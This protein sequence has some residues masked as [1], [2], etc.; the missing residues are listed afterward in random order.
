MNSGLNFNAFKRVIILTGI[1]SILVIIPFL[2]GC[3]KL[4]ESE[5]PSDFVSG[6]GAF[7]SDA[8]ATAVLNAIYATLNNAD[9]FFQGT[10]S[11]S[12]Y[13]GLSSDELT[14]YGG[15]T[16]NNYLAHYRNSLNQIV[17]QGLSGTQ[18]WAPL[19][20]LIF[21]CNAAIE[22]LEASEALT[23]GVKAQLIGESRF[24]R[25]FFYF[26]LVN[27]FGD[28]PLIISTDPEASAIASRSTKSMVYKQLVT[29]LQVAA[30]SLSENYL[31]GSLLKTS[32]ERV[33]PV[34][35]TA[36]ALLSRVYL[37][38]ENWIMAEQ[39]ASL[40]I[41]NSQYSL[42]PLTEVFLKTSK[43]AIWQLQPTAINFNT[44][45]AQTTVIPQAG[46]NTTTN[47]VFLSDT[48]LNSFETGDL[49]Y[50]LGNWV[51]TTIYKVT[52]TLY[53]TVAY[54]NKYKYNLSDPS[55]TTTTG[56][57]NMKEYFVVLR[58]AE[59]YL[60]RAEAR[61]QQGNFNGGKD[62]LNII[63]KRAFGGSKPTVA[64]D[65]TTLLAAI[66]QERKA[67]LF[68]EFGHR[69]LDLKRTGKIEEVMNGITPLKA[70]GLPWMS[71]QQ[72][73]PIPLSDINKDPYLTQNDG[74]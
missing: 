44:T 46:P 70:G 30:S 49:R 6:A 9:G 40:L 13:A 23:P 5:P 73:Y 74:Y 58:L 8:S 19:Y 47:P 34:K 71:Y 52:A 1:L 35:A 54:S 51:D 37:Y 43:E 12:L 39:T 59:Q 62:D 64:T 68:E 11:I 61:A 4:V 18:F 29:D 55:I 20:S 14:L 67:E 72:L 16:D 10:K 50:Q 33:R 15:V 38:E 60:I 53:D 24:L 69:W 26:Y 25:A 63:R 41:N 66:L 45:E 28:V 31:D 65:Q 17:G 2:S 32:T 57:A 27:L 56:T 22:E 7:S 3:K 48:L 36:L 21:R 42:P